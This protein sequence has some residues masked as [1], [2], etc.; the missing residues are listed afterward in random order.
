ME[1]LIKTFENYGMKVVLE[2]DPRKEHDYLLFFPEVSQPGW[3]LLGK[4]KDNNLVIH[5]RIGMEGINFNLGDVNNI[6]EEY[7]EG[8]KEIYQKMEEGIRKEKEMEAF[9]MGE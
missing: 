6:P 9:L 4:I 2:N 3:F 7:M 1:N 5:Q 8:L